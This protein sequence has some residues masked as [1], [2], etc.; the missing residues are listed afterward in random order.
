MR[1]VRVNPSSQRGV[2]LVAVLWI[3]A[4]LSILV[5][6]MVQAQ[7]DE[8]RLASSARQTVQ[9]AAMGSAAVQLV[10]Q[11]MASRSQ[12]VSRLSRVEV[13]FAGLNIPVEITPLNGLID[14]N[15]APQGLLSALFTKAGGLE[16]ERADAL[17]RTIVAARAPGPATQR[18]SRFEAV[19]ELLQVPG[20]DYP[21][22]ARLSSL[23]TTDALGSGR[24]N[25]MAAPVGV[26]LVLS[27]GDAGR[28]ARVAA[29]R[30]ANETGVDTTGLMTQFVDSGATTRF[31]LVARVPLTDGRRLL[32]SRMVDTGRTAPDGVPWRIFQAEDRFEPNPATIN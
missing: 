1:R 16:G 4:A 9:G 2:A 24:V 30:D 5:T 10:L 15:R 3:V 27:E 32:S 18:G 25:A 14:I 21:L 13:A 11:E 20:V 12:P 29:G 17:A 26:L 31:K 23:I 6:G 28:A 22:Y 19:E 7:R 8:V